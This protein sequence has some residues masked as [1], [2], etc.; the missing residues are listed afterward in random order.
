MSSPLQSLEMKAAVSGDLVQVFGE[1][2]KVS[3]LVQVFGE[4]AE[5]S[6]RKTRHGNHASKVQ[7]FDENCCLIFKAS[8]PQERIQFRAVL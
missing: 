5:A 6:S 4:V 2:A 7:R 1:V 3:S 8:N